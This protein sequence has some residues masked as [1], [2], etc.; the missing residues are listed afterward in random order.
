MTTVGSREL[1]NRLGKYLRLVRQG[2]TVQ[3]T[4]RG[5]PVGIILP[6][7]Q[8]ERGPDV[9]KIARLVATGC[10]R[11]A[12]GRLPRRRK[13]VILAPGKSV[14]EMIAEDRG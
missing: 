1:K 3:I 12:R 14:E 5:R 10:V 4:D 6:A 11:P 2:E 8:P 13:P 7:A 9:E